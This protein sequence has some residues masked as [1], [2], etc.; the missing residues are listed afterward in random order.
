VAVTPSNPGRRADAERS[1]EA[2]LAAATAQLARGPAVDMRRLAAAAGVSRSTLYR[3]FAS[4]EALGAAVTERGLAEARAGV[5]EALAAAR[6][7]LAQLRDVVA[8][9][10]TVGARHGL[11]HAGD[12]TAIGDGA[13]LRDLAGDLLDLVGRLAMLAGFDPAPPSDWTALA[14]AHAAEAALRAA[15]S[16]DEAGG[17]AERLFERLTGPLDQGLVVLDPA[18]RLLAVNG[19]G[20]DALGLDGDPGGEA[21]VAPK[22]PVFYD[23]GSRCPGD[24]YPL[25]RAVLSGEA[26]H[27]GVR[28]HRFADGSVRWF[29]IRVEPLR[30]T[31][32]G[33]PPYGLVAALADVSEERE[34]DRRRLPK[35]GSLGRKDPVVLDVARVLDAVPA[36]LLPDQVVA[37]ARRLVEVPV[38]L[39]VVDIDGTH[40]LRLAGTDDFPERMQAPLALGPELAEDGLPDLEERLARELP[41]VVMAPLWLRGRAVGILLAFRGR[42]DVLA[43]VARQAAPAIEL[44][45]GYTDVFDAVRR[46]KDMNPAGEMQQSMLPPRIARLSGGSIAGGVLPSYDTGGDWFDYVEN[47]DGAWVAIADAAGRGVRAAALG[48]V[49]L[50]A[51]RASRRNELSLEDTM[52][53]IHETMVD[54]GT[55]ESFLTALVARWSPVYASFSWINAGHPPPL[56]LHPGGDVEELTSPVFLPLGVGEKERAFRRSFRTLESG[57]R[58]ILY[59]DG[60]SN[61]PVGTGRFGSEGI[62]KAARRAGDVSASAIARSI[63]EGVVAASDQPLR[64]DAAVVVLAPTEG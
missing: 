10:V 47:R 22:V 33:A 48:S 46:R 30:R 41:G 12:L 23:D 20:A 52:Q 26:Q 25:A 24:A 60:V 51:L 17:A 35:P 21:V 44:A 58:V 1:R 5:R 56:L 59:T 39:Y 27:G 50:A 55:D 63:Q 49:A 53:S 62:A 34:A 40:L 37:E 31:S 16:P 6:P 42:Q 2:I 32:G 13:A 7:P 11:A 57:E 15:G 64:D 14:V 54:A 28:G 19:Q 4:A 38:A 36:Q 45:N 18:G 43:E 61:R 3:H 8:A 9:L 29:A